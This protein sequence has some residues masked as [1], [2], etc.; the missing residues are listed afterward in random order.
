MLSK[1]VYQ[2]VCEH[3]LTNSHKTRQTDRQI[4]RQMDRKIDRHVDKWHESARAAVNGSPQTEGLI[5]PMT[6]KSK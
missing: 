2:N 6:K 4:G 1:R 5:K 3:R